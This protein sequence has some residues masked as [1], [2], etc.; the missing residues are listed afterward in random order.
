MTP[1]ILLTWLT[2]LL[3]VSALTSKKY[4]SFDYVFTIAYVRI[5][6]A[7][8]WAKSVGGVWFGLIGAPLAAWFLTTFFILPLMGISGY[9][10]NIQ[11]VLQLANPTAVLIFL[12]LWGSIAFG[13][14]GGSKF[15]RRNGS[16]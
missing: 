14:F 1:S 7:K 5:V 9:T 3:L 6:N 12:A 11:T 2:A 15:Y 16:K 4:I 13:F 10:L 8:M